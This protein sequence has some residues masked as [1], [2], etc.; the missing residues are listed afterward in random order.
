M[1][2]FP[3]LWVTG[4]SW[5][6][7]TLD[8]SCNCHLKVDGVGE[9]LKTFH[10]FL[11]PDL[12]RWKIWEQVHW[13]LYIHHFMQET[14][15]HRFWHLW[16]FLEPIHRY[17]EMTVLMGASL[18]PLLPLY[19]LTTPCSSLSQ[20]HP[21]YLRGSWTSHVVAIGSQSKGPKRDQHML[22]PWP[23]LTWSWK[24]DFITSTV[25]CS[26]TL[27]K[28][29]LPPRGKDIVPAFWWKEGQEN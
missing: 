11:A 4:L 18:L 24:T 5:A 2:F 25:F 10:S 23:Y 22:H 20:P 16:G 26:L 21:P 8:G 13:A 28:R 3:S 1:C 12:G 15:I 27:L 6:L 17:Q 7:L 14:N 29:A 9:A 19:V